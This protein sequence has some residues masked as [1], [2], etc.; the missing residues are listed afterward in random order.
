MVLVQSNVIA[1]LSGFNL[2]TE[3]TGNTTYAKGSGLR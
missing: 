2:E 1:T 3:I